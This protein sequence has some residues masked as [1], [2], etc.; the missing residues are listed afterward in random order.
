MYVPREE[1][2]RSPDPLAEQLMEE[3]TMVKLSPR[4][5]AQHEQLQNDIAIGTVND[6]VAQ[7]DAF[8]NS[9]IDAGN[10]SQ[11]I[12]DD[13]A[14]RA[15]DACERFLHALNTRKE[16]WNNLPFDCLDIV[17][18]DF[19]NDKCCLP[20]DWKIYCKCPFFKILDYEEGYYVLQML[21]RSDNFCVHAK[22]MHLHFKKNVYADGFPKRRCGVCHQDMGKEENSQLCGGH[23]CTVQKAFETTVA[24]FPNIYSWEEV[25]KAY[26]MQELK[27]AMKK[28][29]LSVEVDKKSINPNDL[30]DFDGTGEERIRIVW[31]PG[32]IKPN[33]IWLLDEEENET[34]KRKFS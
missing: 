10:T 29:W 9:L 26:G 16:V 22:E 7:L 3:D 15:K 32:K 12:S 17:M 8:N 4:L 11:F 21:G 13:L 2:I 33:R 19:E 20:Y 23:Y 14:L 6:L 28:E 5:L 27:I 30:D 31:K 24:M 1:R 18:Y 25:K 34:K